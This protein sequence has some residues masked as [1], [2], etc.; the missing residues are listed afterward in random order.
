MHSLRAKSKPLIIY[1]P[2]TKLFAAYLQFVDQYLSA[3]IHYNARSTPE[4][5]GTKTFFPGCLKVLPTSSNRSM[6][7]LFSTAR[8]KWWT[9]F[10]A[11]MIRLL[12]S[13]SPSS[14]ALL[15][16]KRDLNVENGRSFAPLQRGLCDPTQRKYCLMT[17]EIYRYERFDDD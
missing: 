15:P 7:R 13:P 8:Q 2:C 11:P 12:P 3:A 5:N 6:I 16:S 4:Y 17:N 9:L 10:F 14:L 1:K